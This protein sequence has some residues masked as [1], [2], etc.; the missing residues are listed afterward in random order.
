MS[1]LR[2][3][4]HISLAHSYEQN[5]FAFLKTH[6]NLMRNRTHVYMSLKGAF[7]II[8]LG[9]AYAQKSSTSELV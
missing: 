3:Q 2:G 1:N 4:F 9:I 6:T 8:N 5:F 7:A